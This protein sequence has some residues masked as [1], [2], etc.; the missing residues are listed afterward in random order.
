[1]RDY[2]YSSPD[3]AVACV[4]EELS[5][6]GWIRKR[7]R[8]VEE[9]VEFITS[10]PAAHTHSRRAGAHHFLTTTIG[11]ALVV[12]LHLFRTVRWTGRIT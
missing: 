6:K 5:V 7:P 1:V 11:Q 8:K 3:P 2:I 9:V 4:R 12:L 10:A